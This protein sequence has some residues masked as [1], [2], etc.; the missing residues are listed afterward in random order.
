MRIAIAGLGTVGA[1]VV[2]LLLERSE[3]YARRA[4]GMPLTVVAVSARDRRKPR[5]LNLRGVKWYDDPVRMAR[6][7]NVDVVVELI[8]G[9]DGVAKRVVE[10]AIASGKHVVTANKALLARYGMALAR[11]AE[12][13]GVAIAFEA[14]VASGIPIIENLR[15]ALAA[16][17]LSRVG[18]I[19]NGTCNYILWCMSTTVCTFEQALLEAQKLGYAE[20]DPSRD[21]DGK[22][23]ADKLA[24]LAAL[25]F[26]VPVDLSSVYVEGIRNIT[27]L[28]IQRAEELDMVVK[29]LGLARLTAQGLE[30]RVHPCLVPAGTDLAKVDS[31]KNAVSVTGDPVE[32]QVY[33]GKGAGAGSTASAVIGDLIDL[34]TVRRIPAFGVPVDEL[35]AVPYRPMDQRVGRFYLRLQVVDR[36]GVLHELT[37]SLTAQQVSVATVEQPEQ[38]VSPDGSV[39]VFITTHA[40][41]EAA[42]QRALRM[43]RELPTVVGE[44][45]LI[46]IEEEV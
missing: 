20:Q 29:L 27:A 30:C 17:I 10:A 43:I 42:M 25:A 40:T 46:R 9:A 32:T 8:G 23:T 14:A 33:V 12:R 2:R 5:G 44:P 1:E 24:I 6:A 21:I 3:L 16:N 38:E 28:D 19:L 13:R 18:G 15:Q 35:R 11:E 26:G 22:D 7:R 37:G 34:A 4:D 31:A 45:C 36:P 41:S 39:S